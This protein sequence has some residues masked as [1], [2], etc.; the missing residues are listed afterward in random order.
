M[1]IEQWQKEN[2]HTEGWICE[3]LSITNTS[4]YRY[5]QGRIPAP[6]VIKAA[7][8]L[9]GGLVDANSWYG[10]GEYDEARAA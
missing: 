10:H 9:T 6:D 8:A 5:K 3:Q 4:Y 1:T 2:G 7:Y